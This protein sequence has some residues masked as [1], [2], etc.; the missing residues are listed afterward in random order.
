ML[1]I[2]NIT[3][4]WD[5]SKHWKLSWPVEVFLL[6]QLRQ[7]MNSVNPSESKFCHIR[8]TN[9]NIRLCQ[10]KLISLPVMITT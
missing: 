2:P 1:K 9:M 6:L 5:F 4:K 8:P 3:Y 10:L 7:N